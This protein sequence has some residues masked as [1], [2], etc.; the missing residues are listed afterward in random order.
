MRKAPVARGRRRAALAIVL[1]TGVA[2]A[3]VLAL[4]L[5]GGGEEPSP[6]L[7]FAESNPDAGSATVWA[8]GDGADGGT[9]ALELAK[10]IPASA[11]R[12]LY[13]GDVY[14][15]GTMEEF[16]RNYEPVYGRLAPISAPTIGNHGWPNVATGYMPYWAE[17][18]GGAT[19]LYYSF[20]LAGWELLSLNSEGGPAELAEQLRWLEGELSEPG[21]C[22]L[23][24]WHT[25]RYNAGLHDDEDD[26]EPFW[27]ALSGRAALVLN[28]H[29]HNT[30]RF[31]PIGGTVQIIAGAGG[32]EFYEVDAADPRLAFSDDSQAAALRLELEP[33]KAAFSV[34]A[35]SGQELDSGAV[36]CDPLDSGQG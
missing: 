20:R 32:R 16:E 22:R 27:D 1:V 4:G 10:L 9:E 7:S 21:S 23:A 30:Q 28:G 11:D 15:D 14:E 8:V 3:A 36:D 26:V 12:F 13:L 25:P 31:K 5:I 35:A 18:A 19:P 6:K 24:F 29:D 34:V 17:E 2:L 33:G